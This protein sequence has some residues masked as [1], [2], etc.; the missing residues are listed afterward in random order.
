MMESY[1]HEGRNAIIGN[2]HTELEQLNRK[3][4]DDLNH[5]KSINH[6]LEEKVATLSQQLEK[7]KQADVHVKNVEGTDYKAMSILESVLLDREDTELLKAYLMK[8]KEL[9]YDKWV[10]KALELTEMLVNNTDYKQAASILLFTRKNLTKELLQGQNLELVAKNGRSFLID[11]LDLDSYDYERCLVQVFK[12]YRAIGEYYKESSI[13]RLLKHDFKNIM[14]NVFL[15]NSPKAITE[16]IRCYVA[17]DLIDECHLLF[18][19]FINEWEFLKDTIMDVDLIRIVMNALLMGQDMKLLDQLSIEINQLG[20]DRPEIKSY[21]LYYDIINKSIE[22]KKGITELKPMIK[23]FELLSHGETN[24]LINYMN[25]KFAEVKGAKKQQIKTKV[26]QP[27]SIVTEIKKVKLN[28]I[29]ILPTK[30]NRHPKRNQPFNNVRVQLALFVNRHTRNVKAYKWIFALKVKG[31]NEFYLTKNQ[32]KEL[33][34]T[35][36]GDYI[37]VRNFDNQLNVKDERRIML[38]YVIQPGSDE[39]KFK[40]PSTDVNKNSS[41]NQAEHP[42][43]NSRSQLR[44]LGYQI[45]GMKR[46]ERWDVLESKAIPQLGLKSV[47]YTIAY[48]IR[49]RKAM[50]NGATKNQHAITEWEHDLQR[51]KSKYYKQD[52]RW[53][54]TKVK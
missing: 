23:Q 34:K 30:M 5:L 27:P 18:K 24:R 42:E 3:Q 10:K 14:S 44:K 6:K 31:Y 40:W 1:E 53:P 37:N 16:M 43:L 41:N 4:I 46:K 28:T 35:N 12:L 51:L 47:A 17:Y 29:G 38:K 25:D 50:K 7:A 21:F 32:L 39:T 33:S 54:S 49:G 13:K 19:Q 48:L 9:Y 52:F 11:W 26:H 15:M 45:T 22:Y 8:F 20:M 36:H 2:I